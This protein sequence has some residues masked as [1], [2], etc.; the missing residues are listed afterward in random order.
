ML[1][2]NGESHRLLEIIQAQGE[3]AAG[4]LDRRRAMEVIVNRVPELIGADG[5]LIDST[6]GD[7]LVFRAGSGVDS[8]VIG[9]E[10]SR[11]A[12]LSGLALKRRTVLISSDTWKDQRVEYATCRKLGARSLL[13]APLVH[14]GEELG[15]L[16]AFSGLPYAFDQK[17]REAIGL[18]G[19]SLAAHLHHAAGFEAAAHQSRHDHL[20]GLQNRR[21][22]ESRLDAESAKAQARGTKLSL[23]L[24]D[25]DRFKEVNDRFGH[26][27][28]DEVL[29]AVARGFANLRLH[30]DAFRIGGDEFAVILPS[31]DPTAARAAIRRMVDRLELDDLAARG[32]SFGVSF[33]VAA[34]DTD[35]KALH[36]AADL[37]LTAAKR[38][39]HLTRVPDPERS[40]PERSDE[41]AAMSVRSAS[42]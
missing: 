41:V 2:T 17:D 24:L 12:S 4:D 10:Y 37:Q 8:Q 15:S 3:I 30:D 34:G 26:V 7:R 5:A 36:A 42:A 31:S 39:R 27:A 13:C 18:L 33:G 16:T 23:C 9:W 20:T 19:R 6:D 32:I 22:Y 21:A 38:L 40:E 28:G 29:R 35:P 14:Q 1:G 25:L 11:L